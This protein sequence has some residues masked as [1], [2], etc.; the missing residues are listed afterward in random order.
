MCE[1]RINANI[2]IRIFVN[3]RNSHIFK[4]NYY[5]INAKKNQDFSYLA[6]YAII[7]VLNLISINNH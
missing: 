6:K 5:S 1:L 3:I 7:G 2:R 4:Y